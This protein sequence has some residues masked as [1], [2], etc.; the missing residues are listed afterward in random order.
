MKKTQN[1]LYLLVLL[2]I[3]CIQPLHSQDQQKVHSHNDYR[4]LVPFY[5]AYLQ[6]VASIEVDIFYH[7]NLLLVGH[8]FEDLDNEYTINKLYLDPIVELFK[9]NGGTAWPDSD[10]KM[11][12]LVDLK[13]PSDP[14]LSELV[15][16]LEQYPDVFN[17]KQNPNAVKVVISGSVPKPEDFENYSSTV[18]FDG[19]LNQNYTSKQL[20]RVAMISA[21]FFDYAQWNGIGI[22]EKD[23]QKNVQ[24]AIDEAHKQNKPIRFWA[25]PDEVDAWDILHKM[26]VD[27]INTDKIEECTDFFKNKQ[28]DLQGD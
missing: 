22:M 4:Q 7:N 11:I 24:S 23:E 15:K 26:G 14:T 21:P 10:K 5:Q 8:D 27:F 16:L 2:I 13:S 28:S 12:L 19:K 18:S 1:T 9:K 25:S 3:L 17:P 6:R 20:E